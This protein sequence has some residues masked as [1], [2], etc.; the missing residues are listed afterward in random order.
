VVGVWPLASEDDRGVLVTLLGAMPADDRYS[1][2]IQPTRQPMT[3]DD[4]FRPTDEDYALLRAEN[5]DLKRRVAESAAR[6]E[7]LLQRLEN[8]KQRLAEGEMPL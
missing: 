6:L 7:E 1:V 2:T 5:A 3:A 8:L 4:L